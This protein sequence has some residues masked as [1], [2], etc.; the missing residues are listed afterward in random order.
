MLPADMPG[1]AGSP[2][3][4]AHSAG[5]SP[6]RGSLPRIGAFSSSKTLDKFERRCFHSVRPSSAAQ[7][8]HGK[9][10]R[11][12]ASAGDAGSSPF[13]EAASPWPSRRTSE[14]GRFD[15][16][17]GIH[18]PI[19]RVAVLPSPR[20]RP[21]AERG[22]RRAQTRCSAGGL[23]EP[24]RWA[25]RPAGARTSLIHRAMTCST[26]SSSLSA[27]ASRRSPYGRPGL[28]PSCRSRRRR[29]RRCRGPGAAPGEYHRPG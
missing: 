16:L 5:T 26:G 10:T 24:A 23:H 28:A 15:D 7:N 27:P 19:E 17:L 21:R 22:R 1:C 8:G 6:P 18:A 14:T 3:H 20:H 4:P 13:G 2:R 12:N 9:R 25:S 29:S 11:I